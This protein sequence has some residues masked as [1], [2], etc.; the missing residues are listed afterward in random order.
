MTFSGSKYLRNAIC[1]SHT[2]ACGEPIHSNGSFSSALGASFF[3]LT[4]G[5]C[6]VGTTFTPR[7]LCLPSDCQTVDQISPIFHSVFSIEGSAPTAPWSEAPSCRS[8]TMVKSRGLENIFGPI[9]F[10]ER[11]LGLFIHPAVEFGLMSGLEISQNTRDL[12]ILTNTVLSASDGCW[13]RWDT[14]L[15]FFLTRRAFCW[16]HSSYGC[17]HP[18][19]D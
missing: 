6:H 19:V 1:F 5:A 15:R 8:E 9:L 17:F 4:L 3:V 14:R 11:G 18:N 16:H 2:A 12:E 7:V 13:L 10:F